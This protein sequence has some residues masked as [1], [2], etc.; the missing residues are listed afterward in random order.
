MNVRFYVAMLAA[1]EV[2]G[3][4]I[5]SPDQLA[6][7]AKAGRSIKAAVLAACLKKVRTVIASEVAKTGTTEDKL[8][9]SRALVDAIDYP[10]R[11]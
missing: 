9:K 5:H 7:T 8:A 11:T 3:A 2:V 10:V 1:R 6:A 4:K